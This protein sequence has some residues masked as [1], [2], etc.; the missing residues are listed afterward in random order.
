MKRIRVWYEAVVEE[1][2]LKTNVEAIK[3]GYDDLEDAIITDGIKGVIKGSY[4]YSVNWAIFD[5]DE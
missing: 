4:E 5:E 1:D 3:E 2:K